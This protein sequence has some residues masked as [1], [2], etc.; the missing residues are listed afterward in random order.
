MY[1]LYIEHVTDVIESSVTCICVSV[2]LGF[3]APFCIL[4]TFLYC[5]FFALLGIVFAVFYTLVYESFYLLTIIYCGFS[6]VFVAV[7]IYL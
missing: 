4:F 1:Y 3:Y 7:L 5:M 2:S 6:L